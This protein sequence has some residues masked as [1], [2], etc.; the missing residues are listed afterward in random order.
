MSSDN[1]KNPGSEKL[2]NECDEEAWI[3]LEAGFQALIDQLTLEGDTEITA[4]LTQRLQDFAKDSGQDIEDLRIRMQGTHK[5]C[6]WKREVERWREEKRKAK[7][8]RRGGKK[9][10]EE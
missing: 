10:S 4:R 5:S 7:A 8:L 9:S 6:E 2:K 1:K 3:A